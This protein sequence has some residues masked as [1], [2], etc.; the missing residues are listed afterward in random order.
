LERFLFALV[1]TL[2]PAAAYALGYFRSLPEALGTDSHPQKMS[3]LRRWSDFSRMTSAVAMVVTFV[4]W[5]SIAAKH[6]RGMTVSLKQIPSMVNLF[7]LGTLTTRPGVCVIGAIVAGALM[8][9]C[10]VA[11]EKYLSGT[12]RQMD[13]SSSRGWDTLVTQAVGRCSNL[14]GRILRAK[15]ALVFGGLFVVWSLIATMDLF[16]GYGFQ[17]VTGQQ[18]WPTAEYTLSGPA[19]T[20]LNLVGRCMYIGALAI[21]LVALASVTMGRL[22]DRLRRTYALAFF[23]IVIALFGLCDLALGV[24][25][26]D[27][28]VP[29]LL[30]FAGLGTIW[31]SPIVVWVCR[32]GS[33]NAHWNRTRIAIMILYLPI[34]LAGLALFPLALILV[35]SYAFFVVGAVFLSMGFLASRREVA[36]PVQPLH[37]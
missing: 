1:V 13:A 25:R 10:V 36:Q 5:A 16:G 18:D 22:A 8:T 33:D 29:S 2:G 23:S 7:V 9:V 34:V 24:A 30:N 15:T 35:P 6:F 12:M 26:L 3:L 32:G 28:T 27:S 17:V 37:S 14:L 31:V 11:S 21:A 19:L 4:V 20:S